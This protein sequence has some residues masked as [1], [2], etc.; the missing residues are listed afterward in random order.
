LNNRYS[1]GILDRIYRISVIQQEIAIVRSE[2]FDF[3]SI[4]L[5]TLLSG[6]ADAVKDEESKLLKAYDLRVCETTIVY[7]EASE[8]KFGQVSQIHVESS[9]EVSNVMKF[10]DKIGTGYTLDGIGSRNMGESYSVEENSYDTYFDN[11]EQLRTATA[12][13][14]AYVKVSKAS[15]TENLDYSDESENVDENSIV[16]TLLYCFTKRGTKTSESEYMSYSHFTSG[17]MLKETTTECQA[18]VEVVTID[19]G[20]ANHLMSTDV[21][22]LENRFRYTSQGNPAYSDVEL[23]TAYA[24][25]VMGIP[26]NAISID[27]SFIGLYQ[28]ENE[29]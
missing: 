23:V 21:S 29:V 9:G 22:F 17:D 28:A 4:D 11:Y 19:I 26:G 14:T 7:D 12:D 1:Q 6:D 5:Y 13:I 20:S 2:T 25:K 10:E 16:M 15:T 24:E 3:Q 18:A 8:Y 27:N